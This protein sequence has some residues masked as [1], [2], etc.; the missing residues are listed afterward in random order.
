MK[1][2]K[3]RW[4]VLTCVFLIAAIF[5]C[6]GAYGEE[7]E[8]P[9]VS[10]EGR[11]M[12]IY[13]DYKIYLPNDWV[14]EP[15]SS[16]Y[17]EAKAINNDVFLL[18]GRSY[19]TSTN[20]DASLILGEMENSVDFRYKYSDKVA[21]RNNILFTFSTYV[22]DEVGDEFRFANAYLRYDDEGK[23][24]Y[25]YVM[26]CTSK[27][28]ENDPFAEEIF[29][30]ISPI[31]ANTPVYVQLQKGSKGTGVVLLQERLNALGYSMGTA[32]GSYDEKTAAAISEFQQN[33]GLEAT[34]IADE[35]TQEVLYSDAAIGK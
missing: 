18:I 1:N 19:T 25:Y 9:N 12:P 16:Y 17:Y 35:E 28:T 14:D 2:P 27:G 34:G 23:S 32:E 29:S 30:T 26:I 6:T 31:D 20:P 4:I 22:D 8:A 21:Y 10:Y 11:W 15:D 7:D 13:D 3:T 33:N 5:T 24:C